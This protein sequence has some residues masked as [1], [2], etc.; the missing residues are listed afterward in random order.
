[1]SLLLIINC[2]AAAYVVHFAVDA[3]TDVVVVDVGF[4]LVAILK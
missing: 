3:D 4:M 2:D 1:M